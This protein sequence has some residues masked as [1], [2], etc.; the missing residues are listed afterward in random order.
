MD[1]EEADILW[2]MCGERTLGWILGDGWE[3]S[4][5]CRQ[6]GRGIRVT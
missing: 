5:G 3:K 2:R 6:H 1:F 4:F